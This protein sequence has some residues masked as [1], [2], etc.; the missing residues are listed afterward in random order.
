MSLDD[1]TPD[2]NINHI[3]IHIGMPMEIGSS[4]LPDCLLCCQ[5]IGFL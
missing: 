3:V 5:K 4:I 1:L 2:D